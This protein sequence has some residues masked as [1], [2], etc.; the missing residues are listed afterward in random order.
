[1]PGRVVAVRCTGVGRGLTRSYAGEEAKF[2]IESRD[3]HRN[4]TT[5]SRKPFVVSVRGVVSP[6][7]HCIAGENGEYHYSYRT[8]KAGVYFVGVLYE[9]VDIGG[10][11][12]KLTVDPG[13]THAN[14]CSASGPGIHGSY[15][16]VETSFVIQARDY[17][18]NARNNGGD[19]FNIEIGG[20]AS[21]RMR[22][23]DNENGTYTVAY[24]PEIGGD[25]FISVTIN[26]VHIQDSPFTVSSDSMPRESYL[27]M[28]RSLE[29]DFGRQIQDQML[30]LPDKSQK[31]AG[32]KRKKNAQGRVAPSWDLNIKLLNGKDLIAKDT[33]A[34]GTYGTAFTQSS[35]PYVVFKCGDS[36]ARSKTI[37]KDLNPEWNEELSVNVK[38][39]MQRL[40]IEVFDM[41]I[42]DDDDSMGKASVSLVDLVEGKPKLVTAKLKAFDAGGM[43][44]EDGMGEITMVLTF[45]A[46][47]GQ[48]DT[49]ALR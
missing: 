45:T 46:G 38:N 31:A 21:A 25:Y 3:V 43:E 34:G 13:P 39:R 32:E 26:G 20:T 36:E 2:T 8:A 35:D 40:E 6:Q 18:G 47:V 23:R 37:E 15:T 4:K 28:Y 5:S 27:E 7:V 42:S 24:T 30:G 49:K 14:G 11:P 1:M 44:M 12:F 17:F 29:P 22:M 16:M 33:I 48:I 19:V 10:S 9:G 41:D